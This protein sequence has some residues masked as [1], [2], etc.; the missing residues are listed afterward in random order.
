VSMA[1][2]LAAQDAAA[3]R[4]RGMVTAGITMTRN[5]GGAVGISLLG[6]LFN[7]LSEPKL[8]AAHLPFATS[9]LLDP[10]KREEIEKTWPDSMASAHTAISEALLWVF[11]AMLAFAVVQFLVSRKL[12]RHKRD[13]ATS[14]AEAMEAAI[15]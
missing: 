7:L 15:G 13:H 14:R 12:P 2:L 1:I 5:L 6:A 4:Q 9:D 10:H 3:Y 11:V 8:A